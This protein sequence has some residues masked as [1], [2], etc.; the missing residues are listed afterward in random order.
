[1]SSV[2]KLGNDLLSLLVNELT[3]LFMLALVSY[4]GEKITGVRTRQLVYAA[5]S[6]FSAA[7]ALYALLGLINSLLPPPLAQQQQL[8]S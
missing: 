4:I 5:G 2:Q 8:Q 7:M 1:M 6:V 3:A